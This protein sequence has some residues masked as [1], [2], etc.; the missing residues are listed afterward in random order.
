MFPGEELDNIGAVSGEIVRSLNPNNVAPIQLAEQWRKLNNEI[1]DL[2]LLDEGSYFYL[3]YKHPVHDFK[4][5]LFKANGKE[6]AR[7][8]RENMDPDKMEGL[9]LIISS[10]DMSCIVI[11]NH[12][13]E[14]FLAK[15]NLTRT[16]PK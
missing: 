10:V 15:P 1:F 16:E 12:D 7:F 5:K 4:D 14:I 13:G 11:C 2:G 8:L 6:I 9:D 3:L